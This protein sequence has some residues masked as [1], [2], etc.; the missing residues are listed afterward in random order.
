[1]HG[2]GN[3][4]VVLDAL[5]Q[6]P[7]LDVRAIARLADPARGVGFDQL[8]LIE[9]DA[10]ASSGIGYRIYNTDASVAQQCGNGARC[11]LAWLLRHRQAQL[12]LELM[13]PAGPVRGA[14]A[15]NGE[16]EVELGVPAFEWSALP[17]KFGAAVAQVE[18]DGQVSFPLDGS[19]WTGT[20]VSMG[21]PHL[22]LRVLAVDSAPVAQV[23]A[24]LNAHP[25]WPE[26]VNVS[27]VEVLPE[28]AGLRLRVWERG[29]GETLACGSAACAT[30]AVAIRAGWVPAPCVRLALPGGTLTV[31]W[32]G[33]A[34]PVRLSGPV[35]HVY[36]GVLVDGWDAASP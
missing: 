5:E 34:A 31:T 16:L 24:A 19:T 8:L 3:H 25:A 30:A 1:M 14:Q 33:P 4:F 32:A 26:G 29:V 28:A 12:P 6:P 10:R 18:S 21:N 36:D 35:C 15:G 22:V 9:R 11:V 7:A 23:G 2:A 17:L 27:F 20:A 13:S